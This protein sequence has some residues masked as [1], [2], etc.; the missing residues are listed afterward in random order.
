MKFY[1]MNDEQKKRAMCKWPDRFAI[2]L[3]SWT[4]GKDQQTVIEYNPKWVAEN[5]PEILFKEDPYTVLAY[6]FEYI[7]REQL[8]W[9]KNSDYWKTD[10][11]WFF[12][13]FPFE[14]LERDPEWIYKY[15]PDRMKS[16]FPEYGKI[17]DID[18]DIDPNL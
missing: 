17:R 2:D 6:N 10:P 12:D 18:F 15:Y 8:Q 4:W 11:T 3:P 9:I 16:M 1:E 5:Y 7:V 14:M 13:T